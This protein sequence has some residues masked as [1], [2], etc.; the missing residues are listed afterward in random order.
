MVCPTVVKTR[1]TAVTAIVQLILATVVL[2][3]GAGGWLHLALLWLWLALALFSGWRYFLRNRDWR[4]A[5]RRIINALVERMVGHRT[6][7]AH[8]RARKHHVS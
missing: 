2:A 8:R 5:H 4:R 1:F 7:R 3:H 6:R